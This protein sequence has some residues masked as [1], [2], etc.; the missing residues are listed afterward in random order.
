[1]RLDLLPLLSS[2]YIVGDQDVH[3]FRAR[4]RRF[5]FVFHVEECMMEV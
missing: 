3:V 2:V 1:M 5:G 4:C